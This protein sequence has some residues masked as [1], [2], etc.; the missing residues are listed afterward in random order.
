LRRAGRQ[1][2]AGVLLHQDHRQA[3][4]FELDQHVEDGFHHHWRQPKRGLVQQKQ[5]GTRHECSTNGEHL[6]LAAAQRAREL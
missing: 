6:L 3:G 2:G 1:R 4:A 5:S